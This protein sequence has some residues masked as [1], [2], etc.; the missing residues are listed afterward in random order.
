VK[1]SFIIKPFPTTRVAERSTAPVAHFELSPSYPNPLRVESSSSYTTIRYVLP[2]RALVTTTIYDLLGRA[3][4]QWQQ[5]WQP[6]G[7]QTLAWDGKDGRGVVLASGF[8][9]ISLQAVFPNGRRQTASE[10]IVLVR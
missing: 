3:V 4:R 9:L 6:A 1:D 7:E 10:K 8:Y 2:D 5:T